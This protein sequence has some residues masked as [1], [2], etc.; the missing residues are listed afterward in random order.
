MTRNDGFARFRSIRL[1]M[2]V[3]TPERSES[4]FSE[5]PF[6]CL[7]RLTAGPIL[8]MVGPRVPADCS[9][10]W[11]MRDSRGM[12]AWKE[13]RQ[14]ANFTLFTIINTPR[15]LFCRCAANKTGAVR[16]PLQRCT[17]CL[18]A[19]FTRLSTGKPRA[20][21]L[22]TSSIWPPKFNNDTY[23][24]YSDTSALTRQERSWLRLSGWA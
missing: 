20:D 6:S 4:S 1:S 18:C 10:S 12:I 23:I 22:L 3:D 24:S 17:A 2:P 11:A 13:K 19:C 15:R 9:A 14:G 7:S 5:S 16:L 21:H 8:G